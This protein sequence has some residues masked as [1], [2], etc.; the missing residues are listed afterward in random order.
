MSL[1]GERE[2]EGSGDWEGNNK[3]FIFFVVAPAWP[4]LAWLGLPGGE[5]MLGPVL[6][7]IL[8]SD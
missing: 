2:M 8:S 1:K 4:S 7:V 5:E 3:I 6:L